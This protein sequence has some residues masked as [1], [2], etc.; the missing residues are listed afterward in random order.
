[1]TPLLALNGRARIRLRCLQL[2]AKGTLAAFRPPRSWPPLLACKPWYE[3]VRCL[4]HWPA[5]T[6]FIT[7]NSRI[8][9]GRSG[10]GASDPTRDFHFR[11]DDARVAANSPSCAAGRGKRRDEEMATYAS[12]EGQGDGGS[13]L[14][15][16][17]GGGYAAA[18][19]FNF[20]QSSPCCEMTVRTYRHTPR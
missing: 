18:F 3:G 16:I 2:K 7:S 5:P 8:D 13:R 11:K 1:M 19:C 15:L 10:R 9:R 17:C 4:G 14:R 12:G 6:S 20:G